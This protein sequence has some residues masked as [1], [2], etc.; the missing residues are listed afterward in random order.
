MQRTTPF[1]AVAECTVQFT[2]HPLQPL[3]SNAL[4]VRNKISTKIR[5]LPE[6]K[7]RFKK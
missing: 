6:T 1:W 5:I 2:P 4:E 7:R 3:L